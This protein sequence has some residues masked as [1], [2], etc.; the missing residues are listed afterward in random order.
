MDGVYGCGM[1]YGNLAV[2]VKEA[3]HLHDITDKIKCKV[4]ELG[5]QF[6]DRLEVTPVSMS[7]DAGP[8]YESGKSLRVKRSPGQDND[9]VGENLIHNQ[10]SFGTLG[11]FVKGKY[12]NADTGNYTENLYAL[13]CAH[14]FP[15]GCDNAVEVSLSC[16][17]FHHFGT[18][19]PEFMVLQEH[20]IDIAAILVEST[21]LDKCNVRLKNISSMDG[22]ESELYKGEL[23]DLEG[24]EVFKWGSVSDLTQGLII[25]HDYHLEV[26]ALES[27]DES[28]NVLIGALPGLSDDEFSKKGDSGT[29]VCYENPNEQKVTAL[30]MINGAAY[31]HGQEGTEKKYLCS[32]SCHL[33]KNVQELSRKTN[34]NFKWYDQND[35]DHAPIPEKG[36]DGTLRWN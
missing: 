13:S 36:S 31:R 10:Y 15:E 19:S 23:S 5:R 32:Y 33:H 35:A 2:H 9:N 28:Y 25:S 11:C 1:I 3:A 29:V 18:T 7:V 20:T 6:L 16:S 21:V 27:L 4:K 8:T 14:V 17:N 24:S 30:S 12:A 26:Q 34:I 22:W